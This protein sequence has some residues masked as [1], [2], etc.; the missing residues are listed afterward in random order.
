MTGERIRELR[1]RE[2]MTQA[3]L[4]KVLGLSQSTVSMYES[5]KFK[6]SE[7]VLK[8]LIYYF[9]GCNAPK[10]TLWQKIRNF[11]RGLLN[12]RI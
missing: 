1:T 12:E 11:I 7:E 8:Y 9:I 5:N 10:L 2:H 6:P 3:Q 4:G